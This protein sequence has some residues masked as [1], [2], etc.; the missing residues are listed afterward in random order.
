MYLYARGGSGDGGLVVTIDKYSHS[1]DS[2]ATDAGDQTVARQIGAGQSSSTH[3]YTSGG[4]A[5]GNSNVIDKFTFASNSN[6][7]DVGDLTVSRGGTAGT[8]Y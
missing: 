1:S 5:S 3:G 7:T 2:N 6:A 4:H 8:Q